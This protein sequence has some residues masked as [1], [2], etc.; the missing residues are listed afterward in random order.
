MSSFLN[1]TRKLSRR[2]A[3]LRRRRCCFSASVSLISG[4]FV[5]VGARRVS[6]LGSLISSRSDANFD[7]AGGAADIGFLE[8]AGFAVEADGLEDAAALEAPG[9]VISSFER[10]TFGASS[11]LIGALEKSG[12]DESGFWPGFAI[13]RFPGSSP[14][15][16]LAVVLAGAAVGF[17][18]A[19]LA[20]KEVE[21]LGAGW[22]V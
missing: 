18:P 10:S 7:L 9:F 21:G 5:G 17:L 12:L 20:A 2:R 19:N 4:V 14:V 16:G 3:S 15:A 22:I 13:G 6:I 11:D 8:T 1:L